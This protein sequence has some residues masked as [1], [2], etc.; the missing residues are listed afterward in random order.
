MDGIDELGGH[1]QR[2]RTADPQ[3]LRHRS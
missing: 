1:A 3:N 2:L